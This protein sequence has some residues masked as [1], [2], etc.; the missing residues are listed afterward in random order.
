MAIDRRKFIFTTSLGLLGVC[1]TNSAFGKVYSYIEK[2]K[3]EPTILEMLTEA[4]NKRKIGQLDQAQAIYNQ[5]ISIDSNEIRAYDGKRKILLQ[6]K[7]KELEVL[8]LYLAG[9]TLN[10]ENL[11][12]KERIAKEYMRL[13]LGNKKFTQQILVNVNDDLLETAKTY[14][15]QVKIEIPSDVQVK[16]Q[17]EKALKKI[18]QEAHI[19]D[20]RLN[21]VLKDDKKANK[22]V[23]R[24]R[25]DDLTLEQINTKLDSLLTKTSDDFRDI[26]IRELY[27]VYIRRL[28]ESGN[29]DLAA[30]F[31]KT[32]YL[33][34]KQDSQSLK[35][36][37][38]IC[39][40]DKKY[41]VLEEI[42][43]KNDLIKRSFWS[44][45]ALFDVLYKRREKDGV[46][47]LSEMTTIL[48][49]ASAKKYS[50]YHIFEYKVRQV[51]LALIKNNIP[52][53]QS[54]LTN[55]AD[56]LTGTKSAHFIDKFNILCVKY[57][58]KTNNVQ[59]AM[60]VFE[61]ALKQNETEI[62]DIFLA[63]LVAVNKE[64]DNST[65]KIHNERLNN[66]RIEL[67][68]GL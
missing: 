55:F 29:F 52:E 68:N 45:I 51:K 15:Q 30:T 5:V 61:I 4:A 6:A 31:T 13:A 10:P 27:R 57:Y 22:L 32:L 14:L 41:D 44:K 37:R 19:I 8:N 38:N 66:Y 9:F 12:F 16:A 50:F 28:K 43:R 7:Y 65:K 42:E 33:F 35:I 2:P 11:K 23:Y 24:Q 56:S 63:K 17:L 60:A 49:A 53:A 58:L 21:A 54:L 1:V 47:S 46:G 67:L 34:D 36:A 25:F 3:N 39:K 48:N 26:H 20:P 64:K 59:N 62:T 18:S 40:K